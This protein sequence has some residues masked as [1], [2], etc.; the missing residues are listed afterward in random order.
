[1]IQLEVHLFDTAE[2][3]CSQ[4]LSYSSESLHYTLLNTTIILPFECFGFFISFLELQIRCLKTVL[5]SMRA[6]FLLHWMVH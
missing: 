4:C 6:G 3:S 2:G 1:M 5:L